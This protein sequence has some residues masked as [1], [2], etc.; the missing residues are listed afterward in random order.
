MLAV[1]SRGPDVAVIGLIPVVVCLALG[2][3][4]PAA[5]VVQ[6]LF[7]WVALAVGASI[8]TKG[9]MERMMDMAEQEQGR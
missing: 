7:S 6:A 4:I 5:V 1:L 2:T 3:V 8:Q 9:L